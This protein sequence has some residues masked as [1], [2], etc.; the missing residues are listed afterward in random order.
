MCKIM[1]IRKNY[2]KLIYNRC[3]TPKQGKRLFKWTSK[4]SY[5]LH[6]IFDN[7]LVAMHKIKVVLMLNKPTYVGMCVLGFIKLLMYEFQKH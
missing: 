6:K 1:N 3:K 7:H 4:P 5:M 2:G